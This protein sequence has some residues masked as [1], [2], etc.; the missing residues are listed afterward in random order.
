MR[1]APKLSVLVACFAIVVVLVVVAGRSITVRSQALSTAANLHDEVA[2]RKALQRL[3]IQL[4]PDWRLLPDD[5]Y[6]RLIHD[7]AAR[8]VLDVGLGEVKGG[9]FLV[10]PWGQKYEIAIRLN[11]TGGLDV[12]VLSKGPDALAGT[13]DDIAT[14]ARTTKEVF[15]WLSKSTQ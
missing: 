6:K 2:F 8:K 9:D 1:I 3:G 13:P 10:D 5:E 11:A 14:G 12:A 7:M 15:Q 4:T